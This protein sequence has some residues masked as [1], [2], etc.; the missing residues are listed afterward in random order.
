MKIMRRSS[1]IIAVL[2]ACAWCTAAEPPSFKNSPRRVEGGGWSLEVVCPPGQVFELQRSFN[3]RD[4]ETI[5][6]VTAAQGTLTLVDPLATGPLQRFWRLRWQGGDSLAPVISNL[7]VVAVDDGLGQRVMLV[8]SEVTD[9]Q[10][11]TSVV[12]STAPV[13]D[14]AQLMDLPGTVSQSGQTFSLPAGP[15]G[16]ETVSRFFRARASDPS[17]NTSHS[18]LTG[19]LLADPDHLEAIDPLTGLA[20]PGELVRVDGSGQLQAFALRPA[21]ASALGRDADLRIEF[22]SGATLRQST[23]GWMLDF[24]SAQAAF[25]PR[26]PIRFA[27]PLIKNG[28]AT[29]SLP[30]G[31]GMLDVTALCVAFHMD[32]VAGIE[33]I[34]HDRWPARWLGGTIEDHGIRHPQFA[35]PGFGVPL[36][37]VSLART[38]DTLDL[39]QASSVSMLFQQPF[40]LPGLPGAPQV[41]VREGRP[42]MVTFDSA[43]E[44]LLDGSVQLLLESGMRLDAHLEYEGTT[45]RF[46]MTGAQAAAA[47]LEALGTALPSDPSTSVPATADAS[48]L[49]T[50][51]ASL[52]LQR[53]AWALISGAS[54]GRPQ[55]G[56]DDSASPALPRPLPVDLN[57]VAAAL[58]AWG[59]AA[60]VPGGQSLPTPPLEPLLEEVRQ[61]GASMSMDELLP[62]QLALLRLEHGRT[63]GRVSVATLTATQAVIDAAF[64]RCLQDSAGISLARLEEIG[65]RWNELRLEAASLNAV[66]KVEGMSAQLRPWFESMTGMAASSTGVLAGIYDPVLNSTINTVGTPMAA[67]MARRLQALLTLSADLGLA[68]TPAGTLRDEWAVQAGAR[69][70]TL[71]RAAL[72]EAEARHDTAAFRQALLDLTRCASLRV[73]PLLSGLPQSVTLLPSIAELTA[74]WQ[75][76]QT[77]TSADHQ[78]LSLSH[79]PAWHAGE[80]RA[81]H[82]LL[83]LTPPGVTTLPA[84]VQRAL[85]AAAR[86]LTLRSSLQA[87]A[88]STDAAALAL[89]VECGTLRVAVARQAGLAPS[90]DWEG[91]LLPAIMKR[92]QQV[93]TSSFLPLP[94]HDAALFLEESALH[95]VQSG[96]G[97]PDARLALLEAARSISGLRMLTLQSLQAVQTEAFHAGGP[98]PGTLVLPGDITV[99]QLGGSLAF[100][101]ESQTLEGSF[102]G[103][104]AVPNFGG[105][106]AIQQGSITS[107][108]DFEIIAHGTLTLPPNAGGAFSATLT[109]PSTSPVKISYRV[110]GELEFEG[111][112]LLSLSNGMSVYV[113]ASFLDPVYQFSFEARGLA[114]RMLG[115]LVDYLPAFTLPPVITSQA[116][117]LDL[118]AS[119]LDSLGGTV[120]TMTPDEPASPPPPA[121]LAAP[122][123]AVA[124]PP[125]E[126]KAV[127]ASADVA[128]LGATGPEPL[129]PDAWKNMAEVLLS[130][131]SGGLQEIQ[132]AMG[133][134]A[135]GV[136]PP[137]PPAGQAAVAG[138]LSSPP[139]PVEPVFLQLDLGSSAQ[140]YTGPGPGQADARFPA[141][142]EWVPVSSNA[143]VSDGTTNSTSIG[144]I[145]GQ[146][147]ES[148]AYNYGSMPLVP[149]ST[150]TDLPPFFN[151]NLMRDGLEVLPLAG[152]T[153][154]MTFVMLLQ[155]LPPSVYVVCATSMRRIRP[156]SG[157][158]SKADD[159]IT[160]GLR[161]PD[162]K[163]RLGHPIQLNDMGADAGRWV[164]NQNYAFGVV[165]VKTGES[166]LVHSSPGPSWA[167]P[168]VARGA[169]NSLQLIQIPLQI[170]DY[171]ATP[172]T[173]ASSKVE[174]GTVVKLAYTVYGAE[175]V[176]IDPEAGSGL[177]PLTGNLT[178]RPRQTTTYKLTASFGGIE[179][180]SLLTVHVDTSTAADRVAKAT[181]KFNE[182]LE[183]VL[184]AMGE[185]HKK[186]LANEAVDV[187]WT[188]LA[189]QFIKARQIIQ[190]A[191]ADPKISKDPRALRQLSRL[192]IKGLRGEQMVG[193][194][195]SGLAEVFAEALVRGAAASQRDYLTTEG[196]VDQA[197]LTAMSTEK[198]NQK[199]AEITRFYEDAAQTGTPNVGNPAASLALLTEVRKRALASLHFIESSGTFDLGQVADKVLREQTKLL[200]TTDLNASIG[201]L[202]AWQPLPETRYAVLNAEI[203]QRGIAHANKAASW[204]T[205]TAGL[206][207]ALA[208]QNASAR[209]LDAAPEL[210]A[211]ATR[212]ADELNAV[213][214]LPDSA[215]VSSMSLV[216]QIASIDTAAATSSGLVDKIAAWVAKVQPAADTELTRAWTASDLTLGE[217]ILAL[218]LQVSDW[219]TRFPAVATAASPTPKVL[220]AR[221]M[222][223]LGDIQADARTAKRFAGMIKSLTEGANK[224]LSPPTPP[225][226]AVAAGGS[227]GDA[228]PPPPPENALNAADLLAA[229]TALAQHGASGIQSMLAWIDGLPSIP[230]GLQIPGDVRLERIGGSVTYDR[231]TGFLEGAFLG[232]L[233]IPSS[234]FF[235]EVTHASINTDG[236]YSLALA[237]GATLPVADGSNLRLELGTLQAQG[238]AGGQFALSGNGSMIFMNGPGGAEG[239]KFN[240]SFAYDSQLRRLQAEGAAGQVTL[241]FTPDLAL[242]HGSVGLD[243]SAS[244]PA[245]MQISGSLGLIARGTPPAAPTED[246]FQLVAEIAPTRLEFNGDI[247]TTTLTG[248]TLK[249]PPGLLGDGSERVSAAITS[250]IAI[251]ANRVT[252]E[253]SVDFNELTVELTLPGGTVVEAGVSYNSTTRVLRLEGISENLNLTVGDHLAVL[254]ANFAL[255][256]G[257]V[258][259]QALP[260]GGMVQFGG[261]F[262]LLRHD[263]P[264][265]TTGTPHVSDYHLALENGLVRLAFVPGTFT[266]T[267]AQGTLLLPEMF[268]SDTGRARVSVAPMSPPRMIFAFAPS[269]PGMPPALSTF[270]L[271][272]AVDFADLGLAIPDFEGAGARE[273]A[274]SLD[275]GSLPLSTSGAILAA[276]APKLTITN[277]FIFFPHP[278]EETSIEIQAVNARWKLDGFPVGTLGLASDVELLDA[279]VFTLTMLGAP[280]AQTTG[281]EILPP[282]AGATLP[283]LRIFG[284]LKALVD[285][286]LITRDTTNQALAGIPV[287]QFGSIV[288]GELTLHAPVGNALPE[289]EFVLGDVVLTGTFRIGG[290]NGVHVTGPSSGGPA[291]IGLS[292][293]GNLFN[294]ADLP[295]RQFIVTLNGKIVQDGLPGFGMKNTRFVFFALDQPPR[296]EPDEL[297]YD[298]TS[299]DLAGDLPIRLDQAILNLNGSLP[300]DQMLLPQN[301][302]IT[303]TFRIGFPTVADPVVGGGADN[304][305]VTFLPDGT[306]QVQNLEGIELTLNPGIKIPPIEELGGTLYLTGFNN[307]ENLLMAGR[308]SGSVNGYKMK[309]IAAMRATGPL[310]LAVDVNAGSLGIPLGPTGFLF[311]GAGGGISFLNTSA[312]PMDLRS[313]VQEVAGKFQ[314]HPTNPP[315][316]A[317]MNWTGFKNWRDK[318]LSQIP[319]FPP[320]GTGPPLEVI[321]PGTYPA[322]DPIGC[323]VNIPPASANIFGMPHPDQTMF[324]GSYILK[325]SSIPES[326]LNDEIVQGGMGIT[327]QSIQNAVET[328]GALAVALAHQIRQQ[329]DAET[330][331]VP[332]QLGSGAQNAFA[333]FLNEIETG[334]ATLF[335]QA[336]AALPPNATAAQIYA[337]IRDKAYAGIPVQDATMSV[338][339]VFTHAAISSFMN[340]E[341]GGTIGTTGS[342]GVTGRVNFLGLPVGEGK[343]FLSAT[344]VNG[345]PNPQLTGDLSMALG[346]LQFGSTKAVLKAEGAITGLAA[347]VGQ[348]AN[349]LG[350][351]L[352]NEIMANVSPELAGMTLAQ[353]E[354]AVIDG[355]PVAEHANRLATFH[356]AFLAQVLRRPPDTLSDALLG[357][358]ASLLD[359]VNPELVICA[360]GNIKFAGFKVSNGLANFRFRMRKTGR[361]A[362]FDVAPLGFI[363]YGTPLAML[364]SG[365]DR[366][367]MAYAETFPDVTGLLKRLLNGKINSPA[368]IQ[369]EARYQIASMLENGTLT[370]TYDLNPLG[371]SLFRANARMINP[372]LTAHPVV[373]NNNASP[374]DNWVRP[375]TGVNNKIPTREELLLQAVRKEA[376]G[377]VFWKGKGDNLNSL[378]EGK[379][380]ELQGKTLTHDYFPHG[381][382][383]VAAMLNV[384]RIFST[385]PREQWATLTNPNADALARLNALRAIMR[386]YFGSTVQQGSLMAYVPLPNPPA[387]F[388]NGAPIVPPPSL[389]PLDLVNSL[390]T[391]NPATLSAGPLWELG[392]SFA[393]LHLEGDILDIPVGVVNLA[394]VGPNSATG[395]PA[396]FSGEVHFADGSWAQQLFGGVN[397]TA[398]VAGQARPARRTM[399]AAFASLAALDT[400]GTNP[401]ETQA[402]GVIDDLA[403]A[404]ADV[405]AQDLPRVELSASVTNFTPPGAWGWTHEVAADGALTLS[406]YSSEFL[407]VLPANPTDLQRLQKIGGIAAEGSFKLGNW[408]TINGQMLLEPPTSARPRPRAVAT[409]TGRTLTLPAPFGTVANATVNVDTESATFV[410]IQGTLQSQVTLTAQGWPVTIP[411]NAEVAITNTSATFTFNGASLT[412]DYTDPDVPVFSFSGQ[413][414]FPEFNTDVISIVAKAGTGPGLRVTV[415]GA[416]GTMT[417]ARVVIGGLF[418]KAADLPSL[419]VGPQLNFPSTSIAAALGSATL[420]GFPTNGL[421]WKVNRVGGVLAVTDVSGSVTTA[422]LG[423]GFTTSISGSVASN[424]SFSFT[425]STSAGATL[426]GTGL[427]VSSL[428]TSASLAFSGSSIQVTG[429]VSGGLLG[430]SLLPG[431]ANT[432]AGVQLTLSPAAVTGISGTVNVSAMRLGALELRPNSG[433][434]TLTLGMNGVTVPGANLYFTPFSTGVQ[435]ASISGFTVPPL[436]AGLPAL[437]LNQS[438]G[439]SAS[440]AGYSLSGFTFRLERTSNSPLTYRLNNVA[441]SSSLP[442]G[443]SAGT[444]SVTGGS[445]D[446]QSSAASLPLVSLPPLTAGRFSITNSGAGVS[447]TSTGLRLPAP[448]FS[449]SELG[450]SNVTI[451]AVGGALV[452]PDNGNFSVTGFSVSSISPALGSLTGFPLTGVTFDLSK[453]LVQGVRMT[454]FNASLAV[455]GF[456]ASGLEVSVASITSSIGSSIHLTGSSIAQMSVGQFIIKG[457][458][459]GSL[460]SSLS[461]STGLRFVAGQM[462]VAGLF[463]APANFTSVNLTVPSSTNAD[464]TFLDCSMAPSLRGYALGTSSFSLAR[465]SGVVQLYVTASLPLPSGP[466][467]GNL[468]GTISST[469]VVDLDGSLT[470]ADFFG[471][472]VTATFDVSALDFPWTAYIDDSNPRALWRMEENGSTTILSNSSDYAPAHNGMTTDSS[473]RPMLQ[474]PSGFRDGSGVSMLFDGT[475]D[476]YSVPDNANLEGGNAMSVGC[477]FKVNQFTAG[478][479]FHTLVAKGDDSW[480]LAQD[481]SNNYLSFDT[482]SASSQ[483]A[484]RASTVPVND[485]KWHFVVATY[486][487]SMKRLYI[488][489]V[490][491]AAE[492]W[493]GTIRDSTYDVG[494]GHNPQVG[495]RNWNGWLDEVAF[496]N[497]ALDPARIHTLY[498]SGN[499]LS[500]EFSGTANLRDSSPIFRPSFFGSVSSNGEFS[501][502]ASNQSASLL[503][504]SFNQISLRFQRSVLPTITTTISGGASLTGL[505]VNPF[506][507]YPRFSA[508][509]TRNGGNTTASLSANDLSV[510]LGGHS[511]AVGGF[512]LAFTGTLGTPTPISFSDFR[513]GN[514]TLANLGL[515]PLSGLLQSNG[516]FAIASPFTDS[517]TLSGFTAPTC[518][519]DF[520]DYGLYVQGSFNLNVTSGGHTR[521][522]GSVT[523]SGSLGT[524]GSYSLTGNGSIQ[525][526]AYATDSIALTFSSSTGRLTASGAP[527]LNFGDLDMPVS[528]FSLAANSFNGTMTKGFGPITTSHLANHLDTTFSGTTTLS[529]DFSSGSLSGSVSGTWGWQ[530][531]NFAPPGGYNPSGSFSISAGIGD[532]GDIT[533]NNG[534]ASGSNFFAPFWSDGPNFAPPP[535]WGWGFWDNEPYSLW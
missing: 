298:G 427:P 512:D 406:A 179:Q 293:M 49:G 431:A 147:W 313:Y 460:T 273:F 137:P 279:D 225:P 437:L 254:G 94:L 336:I 90:V 367:S 258:G 241:P 9:A 169:L 62:L 108:G 505:P 246:D 389:D 378:F 511:P 366:A 319:T 282:Q 373:R 39:F 35:L 355:V 44:P 385:L 229:A 103:Q 488:D 490:L 31:A 157:N 248:G 263:K 79:S 217:R 13:P 26:S 274:G 525:I 370:G 478:K 526:G 50:A 261:T 247:L 71:A 492:A 353:A 272:G 138:Q 159:V 109:I 444:F 311:T 76:W 199:A 339:G 148:S 439:I 224:L 220:V 464:A 204:K 290:P 304:V 24:T 38:G 216:A 532:N 228:P 198:L 502:V 221:L 486:D 284:Q 381:G 171:H 154:P 238:T 380:E 396:M 256:L 421:T 357:E 350:T 91:G 418:A 451:P 286:T 530:V 340:I 88:D 146:K 87:L 469:G 167:A 443:F 344:D 356:V 414:Q 173:T 506:G 527:N 265:H 483:H 351:A 162:G 337:A 89:L 314:P 186:Q 113:A 209:L 255:E 434:F 93:A 214:G 354:A 310:G 397:V 412:A 323:P 375:G 17:G 393:Y 190:A 80:L 287:G 54:A 376:L 295:G 166:L 341:G 47:S 404:A 60:V 436:T 369:A 477:W 230:G 29:A 219:M 388:N 192:G 130:T 124:I 70:T 518:A 425:G 160:F 415:D 453:T 462:D 184:K 15:L 270:T 535:G 178:V 155:Q 473:T 33:V 432:M 135:G 74:A 452:L 411:A 211:Q 363:G 301:V 359:Q 315:P 141:V 27:Q 503:G 253:V 226:P 257:G 129:P 390:K 7:R 520:G 467:V 55:A 95:R 188:K 329:I 235:A 331:E 32:P 292:G 215:G 300:F 21:G 28:G 259:P 126:S 420:A 104:V 51:A 392:E 429:T 326:K 307:P 10:G 150:G 516:T 136:G 466:T 459:G 521:S 252:G 405:V 446:G 189:A 156:G 442:A 398:K 289:V 125:E 471:F 119:L 519:V 58:A 399:A 410:S 377:D 240:V 455:P 14:L 346:P 121:G 82:E 484:L 123:P 362:Y 485:G 180:T 454:N 30:F 75:R 45:L 139:P 461:S 433:D 280:G 480:R 330:P 212:L 275:F 409:L 262:G 403:T 317:T 391:V 106:L 203:I 267:L 12:Y 145:F 187:D 435:I 18:G 243:I 175:S 223:R 182:K 57:P 114:L 48:T 208:V 508:T 207:L 110:N 236:S 534:N 441:F 249:L 53:Q 497:E 42:L 395:A 92:L 242:L 174:P 494:I 364:T 251:T 345:N 72:N 481:G 40:S 472:P 25:G 128:A 239:T 365:L 515:P 422:A 105:L 291:S 143:S 46:V 191:L 417:N 206:D 302:Q 424:G 513:F 510:T 445:L 144:V 59:I 115:G 419:A 501:L 500:L 489:G 325:F 6:T 479:S 416:S 4:W 456:T 117:Y 233:E 65:T 368:S 177:N 402:K 482:N 394:A 347:V 194:T 84:L 85:D 493:S 97:L 36:P 386:D 533:V 118:W 408:V 474:Q 170:I 498:N 244:G 514:A 382:L 447:L 491:R 266:A 450:I 383:A 358:V 509:F 131:L 305:R 268:S 264:P 507:S 68:Q 16:E 222:Q 133:I 285:N 487:G 371:M 116:D 327:Q 379:F 260:S 127:L 43:G 309:F 20:R 360:E 283:S 361:E 324:P 321:A 164:R 401:T 352:V 426:V 372:D 61:Q 234:G 98:A 276:S 112:A 400:L 52:T 163:V 210:Q 476:F 470:G 19:F 278:V 78:G 81:I 440:L 8:Q 69:L 86:M 374:T 448:R 99:S 64:E 56:T 524:N 197:K 250:P 96:V 430:T 67:G 161:L 107:D 438:T 213:G 343:L 322:N 185:L 413:L 338:K 496:W 122:P 66:A 22:R 3:L 153:E 306:P 200:V 457:P 2:L 41:L 34:L 468:T 517:I 120:E 349:T 333:A 335:A 193:T 172:V 165:P 101:H 384:P 11:V 303:S 407:P 320:I 312:D 73:H 77:V 271:E 140:V 5:E 245:A 181:E 318:L 202:A 308:L 316:A 152:Q 522:F 83:S 183:I 195:P 294:L 237:G 231:S 423:A 449:C 227:G 297:E 1:G 23:S 176:R 499:G 288:G 348:I 328:G 428:A 299:W 475:N 142:H 296:F 37:D 504:F 528:S 102:T 465:V 523:L 277:G 132:T 463:T 149:F 529:Y 151:N 232:R 196:Q 168:E 134:V 201:G 334:F 158:S 342:A 269:G 458:S 495:G 100:D 387:L 332:A 531:K 281:I 63:S 218:Q 111:G 205:R